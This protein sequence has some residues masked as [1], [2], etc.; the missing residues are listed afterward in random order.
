MEKGKKLEK[1]CRELFKKKGLWF[2]RFYDSRSA[3]RFL[4]PQPSDYLVLNPVANFIECK[5]TDEEDRLSF[6]KFRPSQLKAMR[7]LSK[8]GINYFVVVSQKR[9]TD[10][11]YMLFDGETIIDLINRGH[12]SL[13]FMY[14]NYCGSI[15]ELF[16]G[17]LYK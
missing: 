12:K 13:S 10:I 4:P 16:K 9:K 14:K 17:V 11:N 6:S 2:Y 5:E 8:L 1:D 7:D 3:G 15:E